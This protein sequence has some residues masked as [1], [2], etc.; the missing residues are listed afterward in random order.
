MAFF[1]SLICGEWLTGQYEC[2]ISQA[3]IQDLTQLISTLDMYIQL[4][5]IMPVRENQPEV[6]S[7][8]ISFPFLPAF[9]VLTSEVHISNL[10]PLSS[11]RISTMDRVLQD[12]KVQHYCCSH[13]Q[14]IKIWKYEEIS[15]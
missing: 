6:S 15:F 4:R 10:Q 7:P 2:R 12:L 11:V 5:A 3:G 8:V 13:V 1:E 14:S 9:Y